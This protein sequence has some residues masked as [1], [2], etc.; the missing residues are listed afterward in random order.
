MN[1][2]GQVTGVLAI[3][4]DITA[5]KAAEEKVIQSE[6]LAAI[7]Q[8]VTGLAHES[9]NALQRAKASLEMLQLDLPQQPDTSKLVGQISAALDELR[10]LYEEVRAYAAPIHLDCRACDLEVLCRD[11]WGDLAAEREG[12]RLSFRLEADA[13]AAANCHCDRERIVQVLRNILENA[14]AVAP[15]GS[16]IVVQLVTSKLR[17]RPALK[18]TVLDQ[19]PGL[20]PHQQARVFEPFYTTKTK[21]TGLGMAIVQRV[22]DAHRGEVR[23]QN[24]SATPGV[25]V[26]FIIP[27]SQQ[28]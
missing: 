22:I 12:K 6:R 18:A 7:G 16:E 26:E 27:Q 13:S 4:N 25:E 24:R 1:A 19:G 11:A 17:G 9:R 10:R 2:A 15:D 28:G 3:G 21:G 5:L 20:T 23:I 8:M 14:I